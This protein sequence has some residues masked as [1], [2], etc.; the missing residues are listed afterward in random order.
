MI[1]TKVQQKLRYGNRTGVLM[2]A[3][4]SVD[5]IMCCV[6]YCGEQGRNFREA[7]KAMAAVAPQFGLVP[8]KQMACPKATV[9]LMPPA[10]STTF[11]SV[12]CFICYI[13]TSVFC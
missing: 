4:P 8:L 10:N 6:L 9:A 12:Y 1:F 3:I 5:S 2:H 13:D 11:C 7:M